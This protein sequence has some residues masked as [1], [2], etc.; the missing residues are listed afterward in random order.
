MPSRSEWINDSLGLRT[1]MADEAEESLLRWG[2]T[3]AADNFDITASSA[4]MVANDTS[5]TEPMS[6]QQQQLPADE[7][8]S[9]PW[10]KQ[11]QA[12]QQQQP[13]Q[14]TRSLNGAMS[15]VLR[16]VRS[17]SKPLVDL[18]KNKTYLK[19]HAGLPAHAPVPE[20]DHGNKRWDF[21]EW[22]AGS[23]KL[24]AA[25]R[26]RGV[27]CG[28][29]LSLKHGWDI[30]LPSHQAALKDMF[31]P[32]KPLALFGAPLCGIWSQANTSMDSGV[33]A[34]IRNGRA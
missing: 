25:C 34:A 15:F 24:K 5:A 6:N 23:A 12:T 21:W 30:S 3:A 18:A 16:C 20:F 8:P 11:Q 26:K 9:Q 27:E 32:H 17:A 28:P 33:K 10:P 14:Q 13:S 7:P 4:V 1:W 2:K 29:P 19:K 31:W 22:W